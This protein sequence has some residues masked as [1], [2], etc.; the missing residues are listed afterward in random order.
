MVEF[1]PIVFFFLWV[2]KARGHCGKVM[3]SRMDQKY[4]FF[5][6]AQL[7]MAVTSAM[8]FSSSS[9]FTFSSSSSSVVVM[10]FYRQREKKGEEKNKRM[11]SRQHCPSTLD[12]F[13]SFV[14]LCHCVF[15]RLHCGSHCSGSILAHMPVSYLF[16]DDRA[17]SLNHP[18]RHANNGR[19]NGPLADI[20]SSI[21]TW[22]TVLSFVFVFSFVVLTS[23]C[24]F[25]FFKSNGPFPTPP[26]PTCTLPSAPFPLHPPLLYPT[27]RLQ[28]SYPLATSLTFAYP[29]R[30][31]QSYHLPSIL[32]NSTQ[33]S[34]FT[35]FSR[36]H[37]PFEASLKHPPYTLTHP[38]INNVY[39]EQQNQ[40]PYT[41]R[42]SASVT[43]HAHGPLQIQWCNF[44]R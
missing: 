13:Q 4:S 25:V 12:P 19:P 15:V 41:R 38:Y 34:F 27:S 5:A 26:Y 37:A 44:L 2:H 17:C 22:S 28:L 18:L 11:E 33:S 6:C 14:P 21:R 43:L 10:I 9:S 30:S 29:F 42:T 16:T 7:A 1:V 3:R 36:V 40:Q 8:M 23:F 24:V 35:R 39:Q 20:F 32:L 31:V